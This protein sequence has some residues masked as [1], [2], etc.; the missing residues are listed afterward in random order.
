M[1]VHC[2][3]I[4]EVLTKICFKVVLQVVITFIVEAFVLKIQDTAKR[5]TCHKHPNDSHCGCK[6]GKSYRF[7]LHNAFHDLPN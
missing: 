7:L 6:H 2:A 5:R 4:Y 1:C 3:I